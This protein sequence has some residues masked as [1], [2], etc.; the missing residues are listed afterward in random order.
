[1][2]AM[3]KS[4]YWDHMMEKAAMHIS[5]VS[6]KAE[7]ETEQQVKDHLACIIRHGSSHD[8]AEAVVEAMEWT[9]AHMMKHM[10]ETVKETV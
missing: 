5:A 4:Q 2:D 9:V 3:T 6:E 8:R 7:P 1:M 10:M